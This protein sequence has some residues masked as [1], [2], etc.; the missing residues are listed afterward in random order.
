MGCVIRWRTLFWLVGGEVIRSQL[1]QPGFN[2]SGVCVLVISVQSVS[3]TCGGFSI[4]KAKEMAQNIICSPLGA[5]EGQ[6]RRW[7]DGITDSM[8]VSLSELQE[9]V[10]DRETWRAAIH[11]V[12]KSRTRLSDW[13]ELNWRTL[14]FLMAKLLFCLD[15]FPFCIFSL[16]GLI[17]FFGT[18]GRPRRQKLF[19]R[20]EVDCGC[21]QGKGNLFWEGQS[22]SQ[23]QNQ[24]RKTNSLVLGL[25]FAEQEKQRTSWDT[26]NREN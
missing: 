16:L 11:G 6:R 9:L 17:L 10:M 12:T 22:P 21:G 24:V 4:C 26:E 25:L 14:T 13:T 23:L 18:R 19:C 15:S 20:Q 5:T 8:D 7:L 3:S 2:Y 1:H